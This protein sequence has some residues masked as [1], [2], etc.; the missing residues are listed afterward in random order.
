MK[1]IFILYGLLLVMGINLSAQSKGFVSCEGKNFIDASGKVF[2]PKGI[3]LGNWLN[4]EGY[5]F[6]FENVS[7][8]RLIDN[9]FKELIG[10]DETRK[11]WKTFRDNYITK[12]DIHFIKSTGLN[13]IRVPFNFKLFLLR[14]ILKYI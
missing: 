5:M 12:E 2:I 10:A 14:I 9:A 3:N 13:H 8:F 11:F 6:R 4:P 7:S 1:K